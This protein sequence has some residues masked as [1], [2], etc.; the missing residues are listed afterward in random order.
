MPER[1]ISA[2][3]VVWIASWILAARWSRP[4]EARSGVAGD[5]AY[6]VLMAVGVVLLFG[7]FTADFDR[8]HRAWAQPAGFAAWL[9]VVV[10]AAAF[11]FCWWARLHLGRLWSS[12]VTR[13]ADHRIIDTGP[14]AMVRHPIYTGLI[15]AL[16]AT[17]ADHGTDLSIL[18]G[19]LM[20]AGMVAKARREERFLRREL[21]PQAY[22]SYPRA[23][24]SSRRRQ[25]CSTPRRRHGRS[26]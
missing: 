6:R 5:S 18:G 4:A 21:G 14:Y 26:R 23:G 9:L 16:V 8:A 2:L 7:F 11:L 12:A 25:R 10:A 3:W 15:L 17:A 20:A 24:A 22:D 1:A 13:K 19:A